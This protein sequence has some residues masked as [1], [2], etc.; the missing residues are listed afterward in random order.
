MNIQGKQSANR[1]DRTDRNQSDRA[2]KNQ[3]DREGR[4]YPAMKRHLAEGASSKGDPRGRPEILEQDLAY[5]WHALPLMQSLPLVDGDA[6][7]LCYAGRSGGPQGPDIRDAILQFAPEHA[8]TAAERIT[9]DVEFHVRCSD[10]YAH[11]HHTDPRYNNVILHVVLLF[12]SAGPVLRQDGQAVPVCS[13]NDLVPA[14]FPQPLWPCQCIMPSMDAPARAALLQRAGLLR[15]EQKTQHLLAQLQLSQP[16]A[17]FSS[18]DVCLIPAL[19][20]ALGY[21]RDRAFFRAVGQR[22]VGLPGDIPEPAGR[23]AEPSP[24]DAG[25]LRISGQIVEQWRETGA[26]E[27]IRHILTGLG[28]TSMYDEGRPQGAPPFPTTTP[29]PT[30]NDDGRDTNRS[31]S[32]G[33]GGVEWG[34]AP[35]GRP[36]LR[37]ANEQM[38]DVITSLRAIFPGIG[39]ARADILICNVVLPFAA[40]V[41]HFE[42]DQRLLERAGE[43]YEAYPGLSSNQVTRSMCRQ[44]GLER[45]PGSACQQQ[46]LHYIYAQTCREKQCAACFVVGREM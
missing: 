8:G 22:L 10:W 4:P 12:D 7:L 1:S 23:A 43:L 29:A 13:L 18:C 14:I 6:C 11:R 25:R 28:D 15:F 34:G 19:V 46:G 30:M 41:G 24:L 38:K 36:S 3:G 20:E 35:C 42:R 21:G 37:R 17:P 5:R 33:G 45:E 26:W 9:G 27:K 16:H 2:D 39:P 44:L 40:A 31:H 32:R